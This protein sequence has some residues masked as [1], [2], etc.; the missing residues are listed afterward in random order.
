M[1]CEV[2]WLV[3]VS[4]QLRSWCS[5]YTYAKGSAVWDAYGQICKDGEQSVGLGRSEG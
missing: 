2:V 5:G 4:A 3:K 1:V